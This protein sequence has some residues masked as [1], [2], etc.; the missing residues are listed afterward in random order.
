MSC[1]I[2]RL[3]ALR[4]WGWLKM[5]QPIGPSFSSISFGVSVMTGGLL[6]WT[7][8]PAGDRRGRG[9]I[10][11]GVVR[12]IDQGLLPVRGKQLDVVLCR[13][14]VPLPHLPRQLVQHLDA[15]A[16]GIGNVHAV[17]HAVVDAPVERHPPAL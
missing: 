14:D 6:A 7:L 15:V 10:E 9:R 2:S 4:F 8:S 12:A 13:V 5:I 16:I 3:T 11:D 1:H 17:G